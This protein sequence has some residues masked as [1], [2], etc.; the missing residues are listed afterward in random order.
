[1]VDYN[2][3]ISN[4]VVIATDGASVMVGGK[5]GLTTRFKE[6]CPCLL[7]NHCMAHRLQLAAEKTANAVPY[8][9]KYSH[10]PLQRSSL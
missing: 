10:A 6:Q 2:L 3:L 1:M 8:I 4:L 5:T 9:A 7:A